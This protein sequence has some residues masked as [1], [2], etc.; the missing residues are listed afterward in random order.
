MDY[1]IED[2]EYHLPEALIAQEPLKEKDQS[3]LFVLNREDGSFTHTRFYELPQYLE[4]GDL[5]IINDTQ[6]LPSRLIARR[7]SGGLVKFLLLKPHQ[8]GNPSIWEAM[9][10]PI[11]RLKPGEKLEV[12]IGE[13]VVGQITIK[14]IIT[15]PDGYK[16]L[17]VDLG[18]AHEVYQLLQKTGFAPLPPYI[19]RNYNTGDRREEDLFQYQTVYATNP[20][21][22]AA[23]TAGLHFTHSVL[24]ELRE[25]GVNIHKLTLHVGAGTFKPIEDNLDT[26]TIE[27]EEYSIPEETARVINASRIAGKRIIAVGT[28]SLRTLETAGAGGAVTAVEQGKTKLY[29]KPGHKFQI[30]NTMLTNFHLSRSS[31]LVLVAAFAGQELIMRAYDEAIK[32]N[33]RFYS[34]GDSMLIL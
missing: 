19:H 18:A 9:V 23:P 8:A 29:I 24:N 12:I 21:A 7:H 25:K 28:T 32:E 34:Y 15:A 17:L 1:Q 14:D 2:F 22:V 13:A 33:Y 6:V 20:G 16:R 31:L 5:L 11:K 26:H 30:A 4:S 10:T 3:R 27:E